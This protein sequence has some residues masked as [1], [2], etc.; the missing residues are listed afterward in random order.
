MALDLDAIYDEDATAIHVN[1][2]PRTLQRGRV[3]GSGP[4]YIRL[5]RGRIGYRGSDI[6]RWLEAN[7]HRSVADEIAAR[8]EAGRI[9]CMPPAMRHR[10]RVEHEGAEDVPA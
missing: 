3:D 8:N 2:A 6:A 7:T 9:A 4:R 10:W 1:L 5:S